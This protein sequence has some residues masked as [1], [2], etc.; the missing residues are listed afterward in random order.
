MSSA[1]AAN[2][3]DSGSHRR[4]VM[5]WSKTVHIADAAPSVM[6]RIPSALISRQICMPSDLA[7]DAHAQKAATATHR[8]TGSSVTK[9]APQS[10]FAGSED[11]AMTVAAARA[12]T[13][14]SRAVF[15]LTSY[16]LHAFATAVRFRAFYAALTAV[17]GAALYRLGKLRR[18]P[19]RSILNVAY[20]PIT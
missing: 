18:Q 8:S 5:S 13:V 14:T 19:S 2:S 1:P 16:K 6:L 20:S 3:V 11:G 17:P 4:P 10:I 15:R 7:A 9:A 12:A